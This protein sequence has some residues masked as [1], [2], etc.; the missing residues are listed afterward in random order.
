MTAPSTKLPIFRVHFHDDVSLDI[1]AANP[2]VAEAR[3]KKSRPGNFVKKV[4]ILRAAPAH[5]SNPD[6]TGGEHGN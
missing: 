3:A 2:T 5:G 1:E 6:T 4:K